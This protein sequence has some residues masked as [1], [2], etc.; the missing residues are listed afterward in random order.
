MRWFDLLAMKFAMLFGRRTAAAQLDDELRFH[1]DRQIAENRAAGM[2]P[3][4]ARYAALRTFGNPALLR[5]RT[6]TTWSWHSLEQFLRDVC[7]GI[8]TLSRTPGFAIIAVLVM[9]L[10]IGA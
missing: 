2:S 5:E 10:G 3:D 7:Y 4:E 9:A 8:R 1:L 6:R